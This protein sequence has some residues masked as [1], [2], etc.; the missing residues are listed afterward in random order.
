MGEVFAG[1]YE[2]IDQIGLGGMGSIWRVRDLRTGGVVAAKVL[3]QSD[4]VAVLRFV[5]EQAVRIHHPHIIVP[6]GWAG[7][8]GR[9]LFTM[10][11]V[12]GGS[13]S[14]L[15][16]DFGALPPLFVSEV[17]RQLADALSAVHAARVV[18]RDLKPSNILLD[19][20][21][22]GRPHAYLT[23]FGI[24]VDL[25]GPRFTTTGAVAGTPGYL[26]PEL[27]RF[28][29]PT[30]ASDLY[31]LGMVAAAMLRGARPERVDAGAVPVGCPPALWSLVVDLVADDPAA[32]PALGEVT[33]RLAA[34]E[35]SWVPGAA[36]GIEV[37]RQVDAL[38][39]DDATVT[40]TVGADDATAADTLVAGRGELAAVVPAEGRRYPALLV[41]SGVA[42]LAGVVL[43]VL[44]LI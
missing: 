44:S 43:L 40:D 5:R 20:T 8:D 28:D 23:D 17:I 42:V 33:Y 31:A 39:A 19:P 1:R 41:A 2:L 6:L 7:E 13:V 4:A 30:P 16:G 35:L 15:I 9:V 25:D 10:P 36:D 12:E 38:D 32:R 26:A 11:V 21:G 14:T 22:T 3:S 29:D 18:H 34:P 37:F 27:L 24:A